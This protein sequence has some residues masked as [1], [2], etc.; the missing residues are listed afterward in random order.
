VKKILK[1]LTN[2]INTLA[3]VGLSISYLSPYVNP[4]DFWIISFFGLTY[5]FWL[6]INIILLLFWIF[7]LKRRGIYNA[8]ILIIGLQFIT[9]TIQFNS[10]ENSSS[11]I[12]V[13]SFNTHVQQIYNGDN[14]SV[15][16][17]Q[18]LTNQKYDVALLIEWLNK[19]G[20]INKIAFPHQK[21]ISNQE[22]DPHSEYGLKLVSKH[23][24]LH[25]ERIKYDHN[26]SNLAV[27][28][29][30]D[31]EGEIIRFVAVHLQSNKV[32]PKDYQT[33]LH[34]DLNNEY[35]VYAIEFIHRLKKSS[36][37]RST[38]TQTILT[39]IDNS[40]YPVIILGDFNDTPQSYTY[41]KLQEGRKDAF[42]ERGTGW[43]ATYLK[44]LPFLRIDYI[45]HD[46]EL[47]CTSYQSSSSIK[48]DHSL[49]E[50]SFNISK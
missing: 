11:D 26:T 47:T 10:S 39:S 43:G 12:K 22:G 7:S 30:V 5:T 38:Q 31:I 42:I 44:P 36:K 28:F 15:K 24:I 27:I 17:D 49:V 29:D 23:P 14:T 50:A 37:L 16:I 33:L 34:S 32:S 13:C 1:T 2:Y 18:Y 45:L 20:T 8:F 19:K 9:R 4:Q 21:F 3:I 41:Q 48:S 46:D 40:P 6:T 25:W 35:K